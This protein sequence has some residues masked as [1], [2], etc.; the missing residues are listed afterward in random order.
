MSIS[1]TQHCTKTWELACYNMLLG[2][3]QKW[4]YDFTIFSTKLYYGRFSKSKN[5]GIIGKDLIIQSMRSC[6]TRNM[7]SCN[8]YRTSSFVMISFLIRKRNKNLNRKRSSAIYYFYEEFDD[9][10]G[11]NF[12]TIQHNRQT[13]ETW[14]TKQAMGPDERH[15]D[16]DN[17]NLT[18]D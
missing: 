4:K 9:S 6:V 18:L 17:K 14:I 5:K 12:V 7:K 2:A 8:A 13:V 1:I 15:I 10:I 16:I 3:R 11:A